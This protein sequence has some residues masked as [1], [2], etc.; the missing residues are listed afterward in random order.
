MSKNIDADRRQ[1]ADPGV[2]LSDQHSP[3]GLMML[4]LF[5]AFILPLGGLCVVLIGLGNEQW[6]LVMMGGVL[7]GFGAYVSRPSKVLRVINL[8]ML[9]QAPVADVL[10]E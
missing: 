6:L 5:A 9:T 3:G 4:M 7:F 1:F 2:I 10:H 8:Q